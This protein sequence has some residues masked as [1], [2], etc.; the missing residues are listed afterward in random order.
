VS[1]DFNPHLVYSF[2]KEWG[3][4]ICVNGANSCLMGSGLIGNLLVN[5]VFLLV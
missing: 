1:S 3:K 5:E 4:L 2:F